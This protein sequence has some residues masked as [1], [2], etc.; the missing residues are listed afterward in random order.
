MTIENYLCWGVLI[1]FVG[2]G[3]WVIGNY[4]Q[5][6][7]SSRTEMTDEQAAAEYQRLYNESYDHDMRGTVKRMEQIVADQGW[8]RGSMPGE[9]P[10][11]GGAVGQNKLTIIRLRA[12]D[13]L[14]PDDG[15]NPKYQK[16]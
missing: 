16:K 6:P 8:D 14:G 10:V 5:Y 3:L 12:F 1:L 13:G 7:V 15:G 9:R 4:A 2:F 11:I